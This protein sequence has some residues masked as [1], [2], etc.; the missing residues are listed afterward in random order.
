MTEFPVTIPIV[1][2]TAI[3]D[4]INP[5]A[6]GVLVLLVSTLLAIENKRRMLVVAT[7]Y[8][9]AVY[10]TY[11]LA[12]IGLLLAIQRLNIAEPLGIAVGV[13]IIILGLVDIKDF[14][15]YGEGFT[16]AIRPSQAARIKNW[17]RKISI[18]GAIGLGIFVAAVE[19][20]CTGGPY[21]AI[22]TI[23][24]KSFD[25]QAVT[26]LLLYNFIFVLPLIV[27]AA[28]A[29]LGAS[30]KG[31]QEWKKEH[32]KWMRLAEGLLMIGLG[33]LLILFSKGI[34]NLV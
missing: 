16:L 24:A 33:I 5:C 6:I 26:L 29:Y 17:V 30:M 12:G 7:I 2:V 21:L 15:W 28:A 19:L 25:F 9:I 4:S 13:L 31:I 10:I 32:R 1:L 18:P 20:P 3:V 8:I 23:L 14:F 27:I 22:T 34:I 11:F